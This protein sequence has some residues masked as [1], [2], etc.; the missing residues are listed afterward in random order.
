LALLLSDAHRSEQEEAYC[1]GVES[2]PYARYV[3][4]A[5]QIFFALKRK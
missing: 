2:A 1:P 5:K 4:S 3:T